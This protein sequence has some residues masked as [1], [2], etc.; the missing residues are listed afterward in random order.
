MIRPSHSVV[1]ALAV[2]AAFPA[3]AAAAERSFPL[4]GF[5]QV[6]VAGSDRVTIRSG[7][8]SVVANGAEADLDRLEITEVDG[9]LRIGRKKGD[10]GWSSKRVAVTVTLPALIGVR[11][12]GS[13]DVDADV[14]RA[15]TFVAK[16]AGSG[17]L[18]LA[19]LTAPA[20]RF[21]LSGSGGVQA[22][23]TCTSLDIAVSGSGGANL[24]GLKC[25]TATIR[26]SGS[27][28]I[29]AHASQTADIRKSGSG[30]VRIT[31]GARCATRVS[32]S[33]RVDCA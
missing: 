19:S 20:A 16:L 14:A 3:A 29:S 24:S 6:A 7:P 30:A 11:V 32:G 10:W 33:G 28:A 22:A 21:A 5:N 23:G 8:F 12:A 9:V 15:E 31:G 2:L 17:N 4:S 18:K 1:A 25:A 27:G 13:A 26:V